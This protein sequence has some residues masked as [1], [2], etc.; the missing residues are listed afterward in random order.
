M[1]SAK[2]F[3]F[4]C[5]V[6]ISFCSVADN[7]ILDNVSQES[8]SF[9]HSNNKFINLWWSDHFTHIDI[10]TASHPKIT[11]VLQSFNFSNESFILLSWQFY[12]LNISPCVGKF[13]F[14]GSEQCFHEAVSFLCLSC[15][16]SQEY[17]HFHQTLGCNGQLLPNL[18]HNFLRC[19][20]SLL[21]IVHFSY[22]KKHLKQ[23]LISL[24]I[25]VLITI[26]VL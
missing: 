10:L 2:Q 15:K 25:I 4:I 21:D 18:F 1:I 16:F 17:L 22:T 13:I 20:E 24:Q 12:A 14:K 6:D 11:N 7:Q 19:Y 9:F 26:A 5:L 3:L 8:T 23:F